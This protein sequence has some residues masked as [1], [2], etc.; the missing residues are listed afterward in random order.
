ME[1]LSEPPEAYVPYRKH[2]SGD[3]QS[4]LKTRKIL[5]V[6]ETD[7]GD[8]HRSKISQVLGHNEHLFVRFPRCYWVWHLSMAL[9]FTAG[10]LTQLLIPIAKQEAGQTTSQG[11]QM[12]AS[13]Y[14]SVLLGF[15]CLLWSF[16]GTTDKTLARGLMLSIFVAMASQLAALLHF[17]YNS[18]AWD[19]K[20][21]Y[22]IFIRLFLLIGCGY[23]FWAIGSNRAGLRRSLSNKDLREE[24]PSSPGAD[25]KKLD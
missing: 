22:D 7:N 25:S 15:C 24:S 12:M 8:V 19:N 4:R 18:A 2:S 16:F 3:L 1:M 20:T 21:R 14:G 5:G 17:G 10:G 23:F 9:I 11:L 13:Y 6:G